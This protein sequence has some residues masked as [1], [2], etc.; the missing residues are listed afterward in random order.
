MAPPGHRPQPPA[1][2]CKVAI[3]GLLFTTQ[4]YVNTFWL[5]IT[6]AGGPL[7][8]DLLNVSTSILGYYQ[9]D[10]LPLLGSSVEATAIESTWLTAGPAVTYANY[11]NAVAGGRS[12]SVGN[13]AT[14]VVVDWAVSRYYRGGHPRSYLP[15]PALT[16]TTDGAV[17]NSVIS[18]SLAA[19]ATAFIGH[20]NAL[21]HGNISAVA[22]GTYS[23]ATANAWRATP[24]FEAYT[25][26]KVRQHLGSQRRRIG[27]R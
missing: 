4:P 25:G 9:T 19:G 27:G 20:V 15:G 3:S 14:C 8:A 5:S 23:F 2:S 11:A 18:S 6:E 24:I 1:G 7:V 12:A 10:M 26:A 13:A 21:A 22:L 17:F 16:D